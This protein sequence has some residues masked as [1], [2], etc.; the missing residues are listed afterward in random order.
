[1]AFEVGRTTAITSVAAFV[2]ATIIH[3]GIAP[4]ARAGLNGLVIWLVVSAIAVATGLSMRRWGEAVYS[5][6]I[7]PITGHRLISHCTSQ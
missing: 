4:W 6:R 2:I 3:L 7:L 5:L 1:M